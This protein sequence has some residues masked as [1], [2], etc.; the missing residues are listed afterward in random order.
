MLS[1]N[2]N[3]FFG[4]NLRGDMNEAKVLDMSNLDGSDNVRVVYRF[5]GGTQIAVGE[6]VVTYKKS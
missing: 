5:T 4:T 3:F 6:D 1:L 2:T